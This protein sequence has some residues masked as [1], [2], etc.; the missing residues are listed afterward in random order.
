MLVMYISEFDGL[1]VST[2]LPK[3]K[4]TLTTITK[5]FCVVHVATLFT[6]INNKT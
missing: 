3:Y 2:L 5:F 4:T 1:T 6:Y